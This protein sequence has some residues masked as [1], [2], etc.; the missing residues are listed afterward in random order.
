MEK[1]AGFVDSRASQATHLLLDK[2]C[3]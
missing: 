2:C 3:I 1:I